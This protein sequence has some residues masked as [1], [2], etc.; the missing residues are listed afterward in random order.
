[1]VD[2]TKFGEIMPSHRIKITKG[3]SGKD[4]QVRYT[5]DDDDDDD[6]DG[7][8][9]VER[10]YTESISEWKG[11]GPPLLSDEQLVICDNVIPGFSLISK[12]WCFFEVDYIQ[13]FEYNNR[14]FESLVL[15]QE[16]KSMIHSLVRIHADERLDFD[17][18]IKGKGKGMIFLLHG[19]AGTGKTLTAGWF[20]HIC[21]M[22]DSY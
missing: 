11:N 16:Q 13:E 21:K 20:L 22:S 15:A 5:D 3:N 9:E 19:E 4:K 12:R 10:L 1:M 17:D 2:C 14:A 7:E 18:L 8:E 6:D